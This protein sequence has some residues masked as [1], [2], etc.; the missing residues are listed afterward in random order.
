MS[1]KE[2]SGPQPAQLSLILLVDRIVARIVHCF[3]SWGSW[4]SWP[5]KE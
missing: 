5:A 4:T 2:H 1:A 3:P